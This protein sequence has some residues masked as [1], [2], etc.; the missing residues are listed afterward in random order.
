MRFKVFWFNHINGNIAKIGKLNIEM[1]EGW[2]PVF[3]SKRNILSKIINENDKELENAQRDQMA[4]GKNALDKNISLYKGR[5][6]EIETFPYI[7][8]NFFLLL[9]HLVVPVVA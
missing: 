1:N 4:V 5:G 7:R 9:A 8:K 6:Y 2:S 3:N